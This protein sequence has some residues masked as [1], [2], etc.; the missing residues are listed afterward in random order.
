MS[1]VTP[2]PELETVSREQLIREHER[3]LTTLKNIRTVADNYNGYNDFTNIV[4]Q[5][6]DAIGK[7]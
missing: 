6:D 4:K 2:M 7:E 5:I 3:M 1:S